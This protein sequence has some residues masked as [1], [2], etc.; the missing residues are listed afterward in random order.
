MH[1]KIKHTD[2]FVFFLYSSDDSLISFYTFSRKRSLTA[3]LLQATASE[4]NRI[5]T[6]F[7]IL[8]KS[9][10]IALLETTCQSLKLLGHCLKMVMIVVTKQKHLTH[11][12]I[13]QIELIV[14]YT[15]SW[16]QETKYWF[17]SDSEAK[18]WYQFS[19]CSRN[20]P[21]DRTVSSNRRKK[22]WWHC[23][24]L[25]SIKLLLLLILL[26]YHYCCCYVY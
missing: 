7:C 15:P 6:S 26:L 2:L 8:S 10:N 24:I 23:I 14:F 19:M 3:S 13:S 5:T 16:K 12:N 17:N 21:T 22:Q 9:F 18:L 1:T 20:Q 11:R 4:T 25:L